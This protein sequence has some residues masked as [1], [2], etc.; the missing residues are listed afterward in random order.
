LGLKR[1]GLSVFFFKK[2]STVA[3]Y[4]PMVPEGLNCFLI[5]EAIYTMLACARVGA[6][7]SVI[8]AG[9][10]ADA[11]RDRIL[12][13]R[14]TVLV[15]ADQGKRGGKVIQLKGIA[16]KAVSQCPL[17]KTVVVFQR[18]G[19]SSVPFIPN[20]DVWWHEEMAMQRPY[21][22]P[23]RMGAEDPLFML[24]TSGS[25]GKPKGVVHSQVCDVVLI[26]MLVIFWGLL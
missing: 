4:M 2:N 21:C 10:S 6:V 14:C 3:V 25:T 12:D 22:T 7:H 9:F 1:E 19:D 23:E 20:R 18:T 8:F 26:Y 13:A 17:I 16:D 11:L 24:Y 5:Y 15:T